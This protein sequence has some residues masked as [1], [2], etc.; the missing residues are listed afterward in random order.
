MKNLASFAAAALIVI[1]SAQL[2]AAAPRHHELK[3]DRVTAQQ[4]NRNRDA[5]ASWPSEQQDWRDP[6]PSNYPGGYSAPAGR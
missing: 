5:Y 2:A 1:S 4:Q 3:T 6:G